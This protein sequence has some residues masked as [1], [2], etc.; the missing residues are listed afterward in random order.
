INIL[1]FLPMTGIG[2]AVCVLVGHGIGA[3]EIS[4]A[5]RAVRSARLLVLAYLGTIAVSYVLFPQF[6]IRLFAGK[7]VAADLEVALMTSYFLRYIAAFLLFDGLF[8][9]YHSAIKG[10]GDTRFAMTT[11][12]AMAWGLFALPCL[13]LSYYG[14]A[15]MI[16][17]LWR[18]L[19]F[20]I[21]VAGTVFYA[22]Y[23]GGK[24]K[25]MQVIEQVE[26]I[27]VAGES[28]PPV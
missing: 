23:R 24:W 15:E 21:M 20:Y 6:Y 7:E 1:A 5:K 2:M 9:V 22:R 25:S 17:W 8:I 28:I 11:G 19:V 3:K 16:W 10:A 12:V 4:Y 18:V 14:T 27:P 13:I 26:E